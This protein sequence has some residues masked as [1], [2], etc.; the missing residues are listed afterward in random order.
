MAEHD[1][2]TGALAAAIEERYGV[3]VTV[4]GRGRVAEGPASKLALATELAGEL[5]GR[6]PRDD[7]PASAW[8]PLPSPRAV[9]A[10]ADRAEAVRRLVAWAVARGARLEALEPWVDAH[11]GAMVR[12][13]R[14]I[15]A[16]ERV[17]VV[18]DRLVMTPRALL[19]GTELP[20]APPRRPA[21]ALA[22][23]LALE[24]DRAG[25]PWRPVLDALPV[26]LP[27]VAHYRADV[28]GLAG[29]RAWTFAAA[30]CRRIA[31]LHGGLSPALAARLSLAGLGWAHG[32]VQS[33]AFTVRIDGWP[34][35]AIM[36][37]IDLLDHRPGE[38]RLDH[39]AAAGAWTVTT[40]RAVAAGEPV[41]IDYGPIGN[42]HL[43]VNYG[44]T[45]ADNPHDEAELVFPTAPDARVDLAAHL[46]WGLPLGR[47]VSIFVSGR[48]DR[49]LRLALS[50]ARLRSARFEDLTDAAFAS[51]ALRALDGGRERAALDQL[52][53]AAGV[54]LGRLRDGAGASAASAA[55]GWQRACDQVR[56]GERAVLE[57]VRAM[58]C[59]P[60]GPADDLRSGY[61]WNLS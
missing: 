24:R 49:D 30:A 26:A 45:L 7:A 43:L 46:L 9:E 20:F 40:T 61:L 60:H 47:P 39:D 48:F 3:R 4:G 57:R 36:P 23:L 8:M 25:S 34:C 54:G 53:A 51:G 10:P 33:R 31:S 42:G 56:A 50:L 59:E 11:G 28:D 35:C 29:T 44:F 5:G 22:F 37:I 12:A 52:A 27:R 18:P 14:A 16:G 55:T 41:Y 32:I 21:D 2:R 6:R 15:A 1:D 13:R 19:A 38:A 58:A 17:V